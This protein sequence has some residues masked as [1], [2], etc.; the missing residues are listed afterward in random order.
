MEF[1]RADEGD[2]SDLLAWRND[3][4]TVAASLTGAAVAEAEH[5]AWFARVLAD[6]SRLL[7]IARLEGQK[8]GMVRFDAESDGAREVSIALAPAARGRGLAARVLGGAIGAGFG[9]GARPDLIARV[10]QSNPASWRI[11]QTCGFTLEYVVDG[12]GHFRLAR[13]CGAHSCGDGGGVP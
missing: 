4:A 5:R 6:P 1:L 7:L 9:P 3:P 8:I 2:S 12:V 13:S 11:F 10:K